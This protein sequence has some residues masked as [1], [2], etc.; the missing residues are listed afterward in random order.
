MPKDCSELY[1]LYRLLSVC[2]TVVVDADYKVRLFTKLNLR[3][4]W[5]L[6]KVQ[7]QLALHLSIKTQL[8]W[9]FITPT[10]IKMR[11]MTF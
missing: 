8:Q 1:S 6:L 11:F 9:R 5:L 3:M 4:N 2:H 7:K 10:Q